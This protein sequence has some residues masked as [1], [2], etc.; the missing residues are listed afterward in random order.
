MDNPVSKYLAQQYDA[1][2]DWVSGSIN[3]L[4]DEDLKMELS[5]GKNHGVWLLGHLVVCDDDFSLYMG[6]GPLLYPEYYE[7]FGSGSKIQPVE[8]YPPAAELREYWKKIVEKNKKIYAELTD[9]EL[10]ELHSNMKDPE[11]DFFKTK[12]R[13]CIFWQL[14][15][16]YHAGQLG[17]LASRAGKSMY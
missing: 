7:T 15:E 9:A 2:A 11:K 10:K 17:V 4:S 3:A 5:P 6:T 13:I 12:E 14:H 8:N 1:M 16:M